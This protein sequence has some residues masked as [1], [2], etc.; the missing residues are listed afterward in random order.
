MGT[1]RSTYVL[2]HET[3]EHEFAELVDRAG[4][5]LDRQLLVELLPERIPVYRGRSTNT[6]SRM[7][8]YL[9]AAFESAGLPEQA[10]HYVFEELQSGRDA[11]LVA[12]AARALRGRESRSSDAV[13]YLLKAIENIKYADDAVSFDS[14]QPTWPLPGYTTA[15]IEIA[16]TLA[17]L[18]SQASS[19]LPALRSLLQEP[20]MLSETARAKLESVVSGLPVGGSCCAVPAPPPC[21][22]HR[23]E[24]AQPRVHEIHL[25]TDVLAGVELEDQ[26]GARVKFGEFFA[27]KPSV[28][29]FFYTRCDNPNKCSLTITK[30]GRLQRRLAELGLDGRIHTAAITYDPEFDLPARL[31]SYGENREVV[32]SPSDRLFRTTGALAPL[33]D[34]FALGVSFGGTLVNRHRI[35]VFLLDHEGRV[36]GAFTRLQW[37]VDEVLAEATSLLEPA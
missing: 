30:L 12:A 2:D 25:G 6:V 7:R 5:E 24:T 27:G 35:E 31:R 16:A 14:Y 26:D 33:E 19:A 28:V 15:L 29:A 10:L 8:G 36:A 34:Y 4:R 9:L 23:A 11:Y 18:G 3:S 20:G 32:F 37:D 17:W 22:A 13:P 21:C 1:R